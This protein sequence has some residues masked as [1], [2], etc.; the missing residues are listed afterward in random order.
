ML[1][2]CLEHRNIVEQLTS[3]SSDG[4]IF[5]VLKPSENRSSTLVSP[6]IKDIFSSL[7]LAVKFDRSRKFKVEIGREEKKEWEGSV[8][9]VGRVP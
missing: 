8:S 4:K 1:N 2:I 6:F 7:V 3:S 9:G 5:L